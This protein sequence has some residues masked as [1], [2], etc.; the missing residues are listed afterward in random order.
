MQITADSH[1]DHDLTPA[2]IEF[3]RSKFGD[4]TEFFL[5]T[6]ELSADL[7]SLPCGLHGPATGCD[8]VPEEEVFYAV[9]GDRQ[10]PSRLC[11]RPPL[12]VRTMTVIGGLHQGKCILFTAYGGPS[13]PWEIW[14]EKLDAAGMEEI[15]KTSRAFW[16]EHALTK[17][18]SF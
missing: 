18:G 14:D 13:A 16:K 5:E 10:G 17:P 8:P 3:I 6:I 1:L 15:R 9:R 2:H 11:A 12:Q 4:R 7:P